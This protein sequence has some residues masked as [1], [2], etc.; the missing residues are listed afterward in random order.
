[1]DKVALP[2]IRAGIAEVRK[3]ARKDLINTEL[4]RALW[5]RGGRRR[6]SQGTKPPLVLKTIRARLSRS[7][8]A[9]V[10][11]IRIKGFAALIEQGGKTDA[12]IIRAR[13]ANKLVF[14]AGGKL[15]A[16]RAV[17]HPGSIIRKRPFVEKRLRSI[18]PVLEATLS[19]RLSKLFDR[20]VL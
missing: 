1:M 19:S 5:T 7:E 17:R 11:G 12:H 15:V 13:A 3:G 2:A 9:W 4:G 6:R 16:V 14:T 8:G 10:G 20:V 18:I